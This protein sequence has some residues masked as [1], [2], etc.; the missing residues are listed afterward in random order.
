MVLKETLVRAQL[1]EK[2]IRNLKQ[3]LATTEL[4]LKE[5]ERNAEDLVVKSSL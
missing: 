1:S 5:S 3:Q 4:Q 2:Q